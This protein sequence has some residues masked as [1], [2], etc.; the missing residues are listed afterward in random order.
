MAFPPPRCL[1]LLAALPPLATPLSLDAS[2]Y[3]PPQLQVL[4]LPPTSAYLLRRFLVAYL[5]RWTPPQYPQAQTVPSRADP[6][7]PYSPPPPTRSPHPIA[8]PSL[9]GGMMGSGRPSDSP[10]P[11][12]SL[13]MEWRMAWVRRVRRA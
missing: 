8:A 9:M 5:P 11:F 1:A 12:L 6:S 10:P 7:S 4:A 13:P 3:P 2:D